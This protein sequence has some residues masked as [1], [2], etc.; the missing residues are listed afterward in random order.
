MDLNIKNKRIREMYCKQNSMPEIVATLRADN[1]CPL[2]DKL[3]YNWNMKDWE[4]YFKLK[5]EQSDEHARN[6]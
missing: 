2:W 5:K 1:K 4:Y 6:S 3:K